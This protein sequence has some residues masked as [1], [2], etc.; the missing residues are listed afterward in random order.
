MKTRTLIALAA[1]G[2]LVLFGAVAG[3]CKSGGGALSL[4]EYFQQLDVLDNEQQEKADALDAQLGDV[5]EV[6]QAHDILEQELGVFDEFLVGAKDLDPPDEVLDA[7]NDA[8]AGLETFRDVFADLLEE[9]AAAATLDDAFALLL[10][11]DT[12]GIDQANA[13]CVQ[14]EQIAADNGITVNLDC[15]DATAGPQAGEPTQEPTTA[16]TVEPS[17]ELEGYFQELDAAENAYRVQA[18]AVT[19]A[20]SA[21]EDTQ[22]DEALTHIQE[23]LDAIDG[24][25]ASLES[26]DPPPEAT[27]AHAETIA[28]FQAV[29]ALIE[30]NMPTF[31]SAATITEM[32][33]VFSSEEFN[34]I[35]ASLDGACAA[36]QGI[37]EANGVI[38]DLGCGT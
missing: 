9:L 27:A 17:S 37:A 38:V 16:S 30:G 14:L 20:L 13:A 7:H 10:N 11:A 32:N 23:E 26:I 2:L 34:T 36:L 21:L 31:E 5:Q 8:I 18:N 25:V 33:V 19:G 24:F 6:S 4:A 22:V 1:T 15:G 35:S 3:G 29:V 28:G 12:T